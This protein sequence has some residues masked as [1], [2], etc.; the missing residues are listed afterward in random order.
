MITAV[1]AEDE[2]LP[3]KEL[4]RMLDALWPELQIVAE[5]EHGADAL[6]AIHRHQPD[7]A[8]LDIRMPGMSGLDVAHAVKGRCHAVFTTAYDSY[9]MDAFAAGAIDY[10]LK[11]VAQPRLAEAIERLKARLASKQAA[12][13][14]SQ[15]MAEL[16]KRIRGQAAERIR[17][18]SAS[19]GDTIKMFPV[20]KIL[21]F[22]SD[23]K[24][25]RVVSAQ[26]EAHVRKPLKELL[27]GLDHD[28]FWQIHRGTVVRADAIARA[29]R[30]D[31]GRYIVELHGS[32]EKLRVSQA[33]VWRFK[34][35]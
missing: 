33:Y 15:L 5:C 26:D 27:D 1:I 18:I 11:P 14:I 19:V 22:S 35:M 16:D 20:E 21:F 32:P 6:E 25:T 23:E 30:D 17:W 29:Q 31:M 8:F 28:Q 24:Y 10:L 7:V 2:D 12:P 9:A 3:R 4:C 34:P 13:D